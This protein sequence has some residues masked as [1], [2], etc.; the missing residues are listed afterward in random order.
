MIAI[1]IEGR[2]NVAELKIN[3][4]EENVTKQ[5]KQIEE[6]TKQLNNA[7]AQVQQIAG[8]VVEG[9][10]GVKALA[11]VNKIALEQAKIVSSKK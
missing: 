2:K 6:L 7:T 3:N 11:A 5:A 4:L 8:K 1:E 10:S 9:A